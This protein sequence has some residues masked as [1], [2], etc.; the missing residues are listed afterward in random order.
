[1]PVYNA[2]DT[3]QA[4]VESALKQSFPDFELLVINDGSTDA[5][6]SV[7]DKIKDQ[8]LKIYT[9]PNSGSYSARN[10]GLA[11]AQGDFIAFLDADDIWRSDKLEAQLKALQTNPRAI[12]I[13][14]WTE[15]IDEFGKSLARGSYFTYS[16][17]VLT[18]LL[19]RNFISNGS[20]PLIRREA[21]EIVGNF[22]E[23]FTSGG[24]WDMWLRLAVQG[25]FINVPQIH[26]YYR[27]TNRSISTSMIRLEVDGLQ[28]LDKAFQRLPASY[29]YLKK[30]SLAQ[31]YEYLVYR[32]FETFPSSQP[33]LPER[34]QG[35]AA[36]KYFWQTI[37]HHPPYL[38]KLR[39]MLTSI[40]KIIAVLL[41]PPRQAQGMI[42]LMKAIGKYA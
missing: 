11:Q 29:Q 31:F 18:T 40:Y 39:F 24:D 35:L 12:L 2:Q 37:R 41:L 1:M 14:S 42:G 8:R 16:G 6:L 9:Y 3:V 20:N 22:D 23:T 10:H 7:I 17:H 15:F 25:H 28:V 5:T 33:Y 19:S 30:P 13:Y 27:C 38:G 34:S 21:F 4:A 36:A 26:V 32:T